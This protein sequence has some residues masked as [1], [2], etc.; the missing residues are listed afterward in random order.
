MSA[1]RPEKTVYVRLV[2]RLEPIGWVEHP[3]TEYR[4]DGQHTLQQRVREHYKAFPGLCLRVALRR[5]GAVMGMELLYRGWLTEDVNENEYLRTDYY[6]MLG[7][8]DEVDIVLMLRRPRG[9]PEVMPGWAADAAG[10]PTEDRGTGGG[11][12]DGP[13]GNGA[14]LVSDWLTQLQ[15]CA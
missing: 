1:E 6:D 5:A 10:F 9:P 12:A 15:I 14:R 13:H 4:I 3:Y 2:E 7:H 11:I 8:G